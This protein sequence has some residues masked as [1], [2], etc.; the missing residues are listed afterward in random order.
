MIRVWQLLSATDRLEAVNSFNLPYKPEFV[1][2]L[3]A[4]MVDAWRYGRTR[5]SKFMPATV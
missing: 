1:R 2:T 3:K 4:G 5:V